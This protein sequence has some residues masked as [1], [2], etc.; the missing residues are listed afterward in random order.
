MRYNFGMPEGDQKLIEEVQLL[1]ERLRELKTKIEKAGEEVP[2]DRELLKKVVRERMEEVPHLPPSL[3]P[4]PPPQPTA[5]PGA[6]PP[7]VPE[8]FR[9]IK[10][11]VDLAFEK[12]IPTAVHVVRKTGNAHLLDAFHDILVDRFYAELI[13]RGKLQPL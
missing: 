2:H 5:A 1:E 9:V 12:N 3:V 8:T 4:P 7:P 6:P 11:F 10:P 13:K